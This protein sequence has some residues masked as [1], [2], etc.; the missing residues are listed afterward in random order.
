MKTKTSNILI[1]LTIGFIF[2]IFSGGLIDLFHI[3]EIGIFY[4]SF[5]GVLIFFT[6]KIFEIKDEEN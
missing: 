6:Y 3:R 4:C 2:I 5:I 1:L